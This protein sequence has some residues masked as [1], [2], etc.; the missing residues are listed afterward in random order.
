M[1]PEEKSKFPDDRPDLRYDA[2]SV[3]SKWFARWQADPELYAAEPDSTKKKYYVLEMLP[4]P[5]GVLHMGH[6]RNYS[7]GDAL[8]R[9][10]W[11]NGYNV[12]HPMGWDSFGLPAENAAIQNNTPPREWTLGNIAK[13]KTQMNRLGFAYD[14]SREVTTCLPEYYRWNQWFFLKLF[15]KGL[16]YRKKSKVNWCPK[17]ATVL[18][19]EQVVNGCCWRHED[20]LV[21][22]RE[23]E[24]W[25]VRTTQYSDELLR[26]LDHL[27]GWPEKV[28][29]MQRNWIGRSEG[30]L[31]DFKLDGPTGPAG[32][33]IMVF[34]TR[35]D[36]IYG[37]TSLQLAPEHPMVADLA[38]ASADLR[39]KVAGL[40]AEQRTAKQE[41]NIGAIEKDGF[42]TGRFAVNPFNGEKIPIWVANYILMDY[43]T[44]AIMSVPAHDERDYEFAKKYN[45][46][47][48]LVILPRSDDPEETVVEPP[49][50]FTTTE[51]ILINSGA[52]SGL[53]CEE[54]LKKMSAFAGKHGFGKATVTYRLKDWG[55][56]RQRYW[57]TPI[58]MLYCEKD[59]IVPV[60]EKDLPVLLPENVAITLADGSPLRK[61]PEFVNTTCPR[62]GGPARRETDT[63]DTFVDSSWYFYRYTDAHNDNAPFDGKIAQYWFPIDQYIGGVEHAILHLIYSRFWTKFMR[64]LGLITNDE[65]V[66]RLF[67]QGMVIKDGAKMSKSKGNVV[68]PDEMV[69]RYGADAARLYSLFAAPPD[70]DL[71]WQDSGIE[72]IQRFLGRVYR[73]V[74]RHATPRPDASPATSGP[75]AQAQMPAE[76]RAI[77]RKLHQT[78]KR[79]S[80]D[81]QGRWHFNT[82]VAA[83]ME[84]VNELY[85]SEEA[86]ARKAIPL[87][88]LAEVQRNLVL[89]LAP[90]APYLAHE[91]WETLGEKGSL[92]K[93]AWP[94]YDAAL[95]KGEQVER[96]VQVNGK[97]RTV[98]IVPTDA[99]E[100]VLTEIVLLDEKI[101]AAIAGKQ[102]LKIINAK[103]L[104]NVIVQV[105]STAGDRKK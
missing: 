61:I 83:I 33:K 10:M 52:D 38:A 95:A 20:T 3:E 7:I 87:A 60:P 67:T 23:L 104:T 93:A 34:T 99:P 78:I 105:A 18:A 102:I 36:T 89:L 48:R 43:G 63:M 50:P 90:F 58:P 65:P 21:E 16:A 56:S 62:C 4:Y 44:G 31:I 8:A 41:G 25:F 79:V 49:L 92:L 84:L 12:L 39:A 103:S 37:A 88:F 28:R 72:G 81:F 15:E 94:K 97:L 71:D 73:F 85:G 74:L 80:D 51:G 59:G 55:I 14:W 91:L 2:Q 1:P 57:G 29:T 17:C 69:A 45:L 42:N 53:D 11:M 47:I 96:P 26:D 100:N 30:A 75:P 6:V 24:Q 64:D 40:I 27:T 68:S 82:C 70:R 76:A 54:A 35:I 101:K 77:Q 46:E 13:M 86:I 66:E 98:V 22:Q 5:S 32:P 19:N 9:Y